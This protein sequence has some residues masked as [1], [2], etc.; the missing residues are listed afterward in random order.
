VRFQ[1]TAELI[2]AE[3]TQI[4]LP[5]GVG[6]SIGMGNGA[7]IE[8]PDD[9]AASLARKAMAQASPWTLGFRSL[10]LFP[11][12]LKIQPARL[13]GRS[14]SPLLKRSQPSSEE[15]ADLMRD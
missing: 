6:I 3:A 9:Q 13:T 5:P 7:T 8:L 2:V 11:R 14:R 10:P 15:N 12:M 1:I 4:D